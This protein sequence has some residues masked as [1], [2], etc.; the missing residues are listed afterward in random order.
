MVSC[1]FLPLFSLLFNSH[2]FQTYSLYL[3]EP[4]FKWSIREDHGDLT[5]GVIMYLLVSDK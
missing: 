3:V 2:L 1:L 4:V 5:L